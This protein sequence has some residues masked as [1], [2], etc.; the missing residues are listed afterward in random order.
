MPKAKDVSVR[1]DRPSGLLAK[2]MDTLA[3]LIRDG[4]QYGASVQALAK[5]SRLSRWVVGLIVDDI[6]RPF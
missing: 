5:A 4:Y 2:D 3:K 1:E 6:S